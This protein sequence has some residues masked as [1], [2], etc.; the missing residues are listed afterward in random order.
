MIRM[1]STL[2]S[3]SNKSHIVDDIVS[4][5]APLSRQVSPDFKEP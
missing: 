3:I 5:V 2:E 4:M 1:K